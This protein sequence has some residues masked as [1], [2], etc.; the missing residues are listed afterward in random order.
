MRALGLDDVATQKTSGSKPTATI[1]KS[2]SSSSSSTKT[3]D[4]EEAEKPKRIRPA[5]SSKELRAL[6]LD[7]VETVKNEKMI[8]QST[9]MKKQAN[10]GLKELKG[11][12]LQELAITKKRSKR[13]E[14]EPDSQAENKRSRPSIGSKEMR[15]LGLDDVATQKTSGSKP[16]ATT[17]SSS[18]TSSRQENLS[19]SSSSSSTKAQGSAASS[20]SKQERKPGRYNISEKEL[21]ALGVEPS[22]VVKRTSAASNITP[23]VTTVISKVGPSNPSNIS[24]SKKRKETDHLDDDSEKESKQ[25]SV[26]SSKPVA[27]VKETKPT[28]SSLANL[29]KQQKV[30]NTSTVKKQR[31]NTEIS[32]RELKNLFGNVPIEME[33]RSVS[34]RQPEAIK[35]APTSKSAGEVKVRSTNPND[36][37]AR[38]LRNLGL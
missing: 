38:E 3:D 12:G 5:I 30:D 18:S 37:S 13:D 24:E 32:M 29:S 33:R 4:D 7:D 16:T 35:A 11:L 23:A 21:K 2:S 25:S 1:T 20:N 22:L 6:G 17:K 15:A 10:V 36:I 19:S 31:D 26:T 8:Q 9:G 27:N 28:S 14:E 34:N